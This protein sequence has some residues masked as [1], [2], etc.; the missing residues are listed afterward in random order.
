[1]VV[2]VDEGCVIYFF[3][4]GINLNMYYFIWEEGIELELRFIG[5]N[6]SSI[7]SVVVIGVGIK[8]E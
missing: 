8:D 1:M 7:F 5:G 3:G 6:W 2:F 4:V